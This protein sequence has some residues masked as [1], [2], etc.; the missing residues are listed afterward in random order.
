MSDVLFQDMSNF[1]WD[2]WSEWFLEMLPWLVG[3][4]LLGQLVRWKG[5]KV[6]RLLQ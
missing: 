2:F 1:E 3:H 5:F 4:I 6:R